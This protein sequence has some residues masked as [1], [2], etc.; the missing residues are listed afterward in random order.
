LK[1]SVTS[2]FSPF[3]L[4][5]TLPLVTTH[6]ICFSS[7]SWPCGSGLPSTSTE[8]ITQV[9][10][11]SARSPFSSP[12]PD[13]NRGTSRGTPNSTNSL[14]FIAHPRLSHQRSILDPEV[15]GRDDAEDFLHRR[16]AP[17]VILATFRAGM[18]CGIRVRKGAGSGPPAILRPSPSPGA[19]GARLRSGRL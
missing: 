10:W 2:F 1:V 9:P 15:L 12:A 16:T 5:A 14:L 11:T 18:S 7:S 17:Y 6:S 19:F 3:F 13:V 4:A 8:T